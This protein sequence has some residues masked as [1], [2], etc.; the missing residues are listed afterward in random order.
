MFCPYLETSLSKCRLDHNSARFSYEMGACAI[1]MW[2]FI[3]NVAFIFVHV[4]VS[5]LDF[6][7][8]SLKN[9]FTNFL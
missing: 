1:I 5:V 8:S 6:G 3:E 7:G 2:H 9:A 4:A